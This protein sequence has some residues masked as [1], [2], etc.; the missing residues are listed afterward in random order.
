MANLA[1]KKGVE[2]KSVEIMTPLLHM[3][4]SMIIEKGL[5]LGAPFEKTWSCYKGSTKACGKCDSCQLRLKG[6]NE[7]E[8]HDPIS[9][10]FYPKW[11]K[12]N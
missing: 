8:K 1:T 2:G 5:N 7:I 11:Y 12:K 6:F 10:E 4:K 9:Y 3:T